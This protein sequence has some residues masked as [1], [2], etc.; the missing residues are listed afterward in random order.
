MNDVVSESKSEH[1][2]FLGANM[3][4]AQQN[5]KLIKESVEFLELIVTRGGY[6]TDAEK[7]EV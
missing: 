1:K 2:R 7:V 3:T 5:T 4:V 6:R